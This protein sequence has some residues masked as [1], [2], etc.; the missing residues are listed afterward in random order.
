MLN[1]SITLMPFDIKENIRDFYQALNEGNYCLADDIA[2]QFKD[3]GM[4]NKAEDL[5]QKVTARLADD[6]ANNLI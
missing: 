1:Q 5:L 6:T 3:H 2:E 4:P